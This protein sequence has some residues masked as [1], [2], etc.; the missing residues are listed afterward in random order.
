MLI[1]AVLLLVGTIGRHEN[2]TVVGFSLLG[3]GG[4][5]AT[6]RGKG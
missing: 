2:L 6:K 5:A 4:V 1:G 3:L